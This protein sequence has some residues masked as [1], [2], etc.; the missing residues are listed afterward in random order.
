MGIHI[1]DLGRTKPGHNGGTMVHFQVALHVAYWLSGSSGP[2]FQVDWRASA[3][4][5]R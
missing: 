3:N 1:F 5:P 2:V 4:R